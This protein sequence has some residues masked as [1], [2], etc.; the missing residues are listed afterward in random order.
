MDDKKLPVKRNNIPQDLKQT[1]K[2]RKNRKISFKDAFDLKFINGLSNT[3]IASQLNCSRQYVAALLKPVTNLLNQADLYP[4]YAKN[5]EKLLTLTESILLRSMLD[6]GKL[7]KAPINQLAF[8]YDKL[9]NARKGQK[10]NQTAVKIELIFQAAEKEA[11]QL[12]KSHADIVINQSD[13]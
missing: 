9:R 11:K 5:E 13:S 2:S 8:A 12:R 10:G 6:E 1:E 3:V 4:L 7:A